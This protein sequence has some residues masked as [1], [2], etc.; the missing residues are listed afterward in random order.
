MP[1]SVHR[2]VSQVFTVDMINR[3]FLE[4]MRAIQPLKTEMNRTEL[5]KPKYE[6]FMVLDH[7]KESVDVDFGDCLEE[8]FFS[9]KY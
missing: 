1:D 4:C 8:G 7:L 2:R 3:V 9:S 5:P 6:K